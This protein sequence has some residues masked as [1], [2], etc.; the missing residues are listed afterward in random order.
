[1]NENEQRELLLAYLTENPKV[2]FDLTA[3]K[4]NKRGQIVTDSTFPDKI[5]FEVERHQRI[6]GSG[7]TPGLPMA[8]FATYMVK[9]V[10]DPA[11][12]NIEEVDKQLLDHSI[13]KYALAEEFLNKF[14]ISVV[15]VKGKTPRFRIE[16]PGWFDDFEAGTLAEAEK[17]VEAEIR[18][19][20]FR[21]ELELLE[22]EPGIDVDELET[23]TLNAAVEIGLGNLKESWDDPEGPEID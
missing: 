19:L 11:K 3:E 10:F 21:T 1:V 6:A 9:Y 8:A 16:A 22:G 15:R 14:P 23:K 5:V 12:K 13:Y 20:N 7:Y 18:S 2:W 17:R 4:F